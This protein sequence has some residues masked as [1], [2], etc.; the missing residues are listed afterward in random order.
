MNELRQKELTE[1]FESGFYGFWIRKYRIS[2]LIVWVLLVIGIISIVNLPKESSP[3]I[4]LGIVSISTSYP[5]TN[6]EDMDSLISDKIYKEIK[7]IKGIDKIESSSSL[8][9]SSISITAK[10]S[11]NIKDILDDVRNAVNRVPLPTDAKTPVI[12]EIETDTNRAFSALIYSTQSGTTQSSLLERTKK[13]K[14]EIEKLPGIEAVGLWA[15]ADTSPVW[16]GGGG[17][18]AYEVHIVIPKEKLDS[19]NVTLGTLASLIRGYNLDQPIGNFSLG[20]RKYDYRIEGKNIKS[21]DFLNTTIP[22]SGGSSI[23]L[24]D[25]ATIERKYKNES[26]REVIIGTGGASYPYASITVNKTDTASIFGASDTAKAKIEELMQT[27]EFEGYNYIFAYDLAD[28]IRDDYNELFKEALTTLVLVFVAMFL[29]VGFKDSLFATITLPLAFLSTFIGLY[30]LGYSLNFL[31]NF[32]LILSFG[33][34]VD[35]IIV[36]VQAASAKVRIGYNP[37]TA[38]MLAIREYSVPIIAWVS[39]TIVV[40][41][42]MMVLPGILGKFMAYIPITIFGV[43]SSG[44]ILALTVNSALY[45]LFVKRK[46]TYIDNDVAL[47]YATEEERELLML[48]REWKTLVPSGEV[49]LRL[50]VIHKITEWYKHILRKFLENTFL[51]RL[52]IVVPFGFF[53][54]WLFILAPIVGFELFPWDDN[55]ATAF[56]IEWPVW[57][58]TE[59]MK[60]LVGDIET[61]FSGFDEVEYVST[62]TNNNITNISVQLTKRQERKK[63][64]QR[65]VFEV[66]KE[67]LKRLSVLEQKWLKV[68]SEV[69]KNGPP[70][71]K[72]VGIKLIA[73]DS[74]KLPQLIETSKIFQEKL[75]TLPGIKNIGTSSKDTPGQ[76]IFRLKKD[77]LAMY[78]ISPALIYGNISQNMNGINVGTVE[79]SGDDISIYIKTDTFLEEA[80]IEDIMSIPM[81][82]WNTTYR[83]GDFIESR[84]E[85]A[86]ASVKRENGDIQI[87]VDADL[88]QGIDTISTQNL[89]ESYAKSYNFPPG[90]RYG[91][92]GENEANKEL[93]VAIFSSFFLAIM[94]IFA[95]LT[96]QFNSFSQ[97][98]VILYSVI[99]S[100]PFVMIGLIL[101]ENQFSLP[102]GIGFIAFTGIA[103]NHGIILIDAINENL[104]K[105]MEGFTALVEAGSSRLE[106]MTLTT[107][108]TVLWILPIALRDRFWSGMGFTIVFGIIATTFLTLFVVKG[109]YYELY[110]AK[111]TGIWSD[112]KNFLLQSLQKTKKR[113]KQ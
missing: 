18:W 32:S 83:V 71:T 57:L 81:S 112:I 46:D 35:T 28:T 95:I 102:F 58:K 96:L 3:S 55:N 13:L 63:L 99:M 75:K 97:P 72:A 21:F 91:T 2:Y 51:R 113:I 84:V 14:T 104:K 66:E 93:I 5:G 43:L 4:Q 24:G 22:V 27:P 47:E 45:L 25:I 88:E 42:P 85:N 20:E 17:E 37:R 11:A 59:S 30:Y 74:E 111:H 110:V 86:I 48:E 36:I 49:P 6:P 40:F 89:L 77:L 92:G 103:V 70:G 39:T 73:D 41:I 62:T 26:I 106:P 80:R 64:G 50:R 109:I 38:I 16:W 52:S 12:T 9:F 69:Q 53:I 10:T 107:V 67:F 90:I 29:F 33:I 19:L 56:T 105:G 54:F 79:D 34:A 61:Y 44:L 31:T 68:T 8:G 76:F 101:T 100:L 82:L 7:D 94:V 108:T 65:S 60:A 15:S 78:N 23:R 98:A 1:K 87:T